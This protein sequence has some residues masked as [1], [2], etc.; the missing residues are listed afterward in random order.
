MIRLNIHEAKTHLSRYLAKLKKGETII[1][2]KRNEPIA[3]IRPLPTP[4]PHKRPVG[5][6]KE[7]FV[8]PPQFFEPLPEE[9][10][11]AFQGQP[12]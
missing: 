4:P 3:E 5:L 11:H 9:L 2:C 12:Q 6:A 8:V 7:Q 1:L 10:T